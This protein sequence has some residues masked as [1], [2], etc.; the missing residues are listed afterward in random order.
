[1]LISFVNSYKTIVLTC[2]QI[3]SITV[4]EEGNSNI[5]MLCRCK[6]LTKKYNQ[7]YQP[8]VLE[9]H[10]ESLTNTTQ[11]RFLVFDILRVSWGM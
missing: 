4:S 7:P 9:L 2:L 1:M 6:R 10:L 8:M 3:N 11:K 5:F